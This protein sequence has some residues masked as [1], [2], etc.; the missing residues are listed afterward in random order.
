MSMLI[1]IIFGVWMSLV[2]NIIILLVGLRNIDEEYFKIVK[3]F[4]VLDG[5]IFWCIMFL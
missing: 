4:G 3:M 5:E 2:F 1:L